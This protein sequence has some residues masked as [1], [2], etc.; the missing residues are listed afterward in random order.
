MRWSVLFIGWWTIPLL[1][2]LSSKHGSPLDPIAEG[3]LWTLLKQL[4]LPALSSLVCPLST[5]NFLANSR[6]IQTAEIVGSH[7]S[8]PRFQVLGISNAGG[9]I[10]DQNS[11]D[12]VLYAY[13]NGMQIASHTWSH[14]HLNSLTQ[15]QGMVASS[16]FISPWLNSPRSWLRCPKLIVCSLFLDNFQDLDCFLFSTRG[17]RTYHRG[18]PRVHAPS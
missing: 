10:Y 2:R 11:I 12:N 18:T 8:V 1:V 5:H 17:N 15:A 16:S 6:I 4:E 7:L 13:N 9:C 3:I 14:S